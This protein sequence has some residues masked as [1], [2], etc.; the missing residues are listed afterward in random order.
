MV[1]GD[2][3]SDSSVPQQSCGHPAQLVTAGCA[4]SLPN[5]GSC[6]GPGIGLVPPM[7]QDGGASREWQEDGCRAGSQRP[8]PRDWEKQV[9]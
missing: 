6:L 9:S 2:Q 1:A 5:P 7:V 3:E 4:L 8:I